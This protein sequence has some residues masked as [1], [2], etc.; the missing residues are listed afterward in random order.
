MF[1][2]HAFQPGREQRQTR[3]VFGGLSRRGIPAEGCW[4]HMENL[5]GEQFPAL[6]TRPPRQYLQTVDGETVVDVAAICDKDGLVWL[7]K[8]GS[9]H[10]GGHRLDNFYTYTDDP[11]RQLISMGGYLIVWPD[12]CWANAARLR[13]GQSMRV[14]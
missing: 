11:D 2:N 3:T 9:L 12:K 14:T 5:S 10:A 7:G 6:A 4:T 13:L 8:D 1:Y